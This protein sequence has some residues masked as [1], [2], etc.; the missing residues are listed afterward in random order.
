M[1]N[2]KNIRNK[3]N[4]AENYKNRQKVLENNNLKGNYKHA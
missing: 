2:N 1:D 3:P 4:Y